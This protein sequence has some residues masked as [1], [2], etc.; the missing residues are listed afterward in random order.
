VQT[1][2]L[3]G[4]PRAN[5]NL[6]A[7]PHSSRLKA[8]DSSLHSARGTGQLLIPQFRTAGCP[9]KPLIRKAAS[10]RAGAPSPCPEVGSGD[11]PGSLST[12]K[13]RALTHRQN[14]E[15]AATTSLVQPHTWVHA[16]RNPVQRQHPGVEGCG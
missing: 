5:W 2:S 4:T 16:L 14:D 3:R 9:W 7:A 11:Q 6:H 1:G 10:S 15:D 8:A 12:T 13:K